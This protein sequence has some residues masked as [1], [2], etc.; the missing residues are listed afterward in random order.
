[1][2]LSPA[3]GGCSLVRQKPENPR[4]FMM[5]FLQKN[6]PVSPGSPT[7]AAANE[8]RWVPTTRSCLPLVWLPGPVSLNSG[9]VGRRGVGGAVAV[10]A[11]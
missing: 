5:E 7:A 11:H 2:L 4:E 1:M 8:V 10:F 6:A 9:G 3:L